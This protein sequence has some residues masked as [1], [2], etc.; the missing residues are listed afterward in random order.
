MLVVKY[1]SKNFFDVYEYHEDIKENFSFEDIKKAFR[2]LKKDYKNA[3]QIENT[4]LVWDSITDF[5]YGTLSA[6]EYDEN[7]NYKEFL[8]D[9]NGCKNNY[10]KIY[11]NAA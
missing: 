8:W 3:I 6:R 1:E 9:Y 2:F 4:V 11:K 7:R 5:K 10:Y